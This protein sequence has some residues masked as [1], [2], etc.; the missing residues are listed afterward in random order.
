[1]STIV[2]VAALDEPRAAS[3]A[4]GPASDSVGRSSS[5][6][7]RLGERRALAEAREQPELGRR[8]VE[9]GP[10]GA[11]LVDLPALLAAGEQRRARAG[12]RGA[13][14]RRATGWKPSPM[15][16]ACAVV[17]SGTS[18]SSHVSANATSEIAAATRKTGCRASVTAPT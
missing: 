16:G 3:S 7:S 18:R 13:R 9:L 11:A 12:S 4:S 17:F 10:R 2:A 5:A 8:E 6:S 1:M 14:R 15:S